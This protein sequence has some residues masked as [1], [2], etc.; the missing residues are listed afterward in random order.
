MVNTNTAPKPAPGEVLEDPN[1]GN[2]FW[3]ACRDPW[4]I[5][6]DAVTSGDAASV[7][8]ARKLNT[9]IK[10]KTGGDPSKI[11]TG[12][13]LNG[14]QIDSGNE[15]AFFAPFAVSAIADPDSQAWLDALWNQMLKAPFGSN[16]YYST[17]IQLQVMIIV[18]G[19]YWVP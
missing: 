19:N 2:Y 10:A 12:Y 1:D 11:A 6:A 17:S 15:P 14:T 3:N 7:A 18:S 4:R 5:G 13:K 16:D 9:W 8:S